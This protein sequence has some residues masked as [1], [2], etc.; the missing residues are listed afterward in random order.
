MVKPK[1]C[2]FCRNEFI[3]SKPLQSVCSAPCA[4]G[5]ARANGIKKMEQETKAKR[6]ELKEKIKG[7]GDYKR[8]LQT[9][10]NRIARLIDEGCPCISSGRMT[11]KMNGGHRLAVGGWSSLRFN[12]LN[13]WI[14]SFSDNHHLSGS[15]TYYDISLAKM[16]IYNLVHDLPKIYPTI[17][18]SIEDLKAAIIKA[19]H[20]EK[21][22][23][24]MNKTE[25]LPRSTDRRIELRVQF[26]KYIGIYD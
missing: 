21:G 22:L 24:D 9:I 5:L 20:V 16:G 11:G 17:K 10:V 18:L 1:K 6:K 2:K 23:V 19:K 7:S 14:Q 4:F 3:P 25:Q 12:L 13:I 8:E 26:N 15:P